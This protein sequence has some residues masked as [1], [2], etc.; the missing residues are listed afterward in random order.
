MRRKR[1]G[2]LP[3]GCPATSGQPPGSCPEIDRQFRRM[4]RRMDF[5]NAAGNPADS[6]AEGGRNGGAIAAEEPPENRRTQNPSVTKGFGLSC[7]K[8]IAT[9]F[10]SFVA[11]ILRASF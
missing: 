6:P 8:R 2:Y 9:H 4:I 10:A 5:G 1:P 11:T 3:G 7:L